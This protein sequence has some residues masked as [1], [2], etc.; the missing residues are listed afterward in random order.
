MP[1]PGEKSNPLGL[2][3]FLDDLQLD[4]YE[5]LLDE[6]EELYRE[7][8]EARR[9]P[10]DE[11]DEVGES[12]PLLTLTV[13]GGEGLAF[14]ELPLLSFGLVRVAAVG[15]NGFRL[16]PISHPLPGYA[17]LKDPRKYLEDLLARSG[18]SE[19]SYALNTFFQA[20]GISLED[21][22]EHYAKDLKA[23]VGIFRDLL[24]WAY[25][26]WTVE[27]VLGDDYR[28][29]LFVKDGRLAQTGVKDEFRTKLREYFRRKD[30]LLVGV[31][32]RSRLLAEGLTSL[33]MARLFAEVR[34]TFLLRVPEAIMEKAYRYERQWDA[35]FQGA[36]VMGTRYVARLFESTFRPRE[37]IV[38]LDLPPHLE[39]EDAIRVAKS[40]KSHRSVLYKGSLGPVVEAHGK[41]SVAKPL[42]T[43]MEDEV[44]SRLRKSFGEEFARKIAEWLRLAERE[45]GRG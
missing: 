18:E 14:E 30:L 42:A 10:L 7:V 2:K 15:V 43:S 25:L 8:K 28:K 41:A 32:K 17:V 21:L 38:I 40:L 34:G 22:G 33:V 6:L 24:E 5:E 23:F 37:G 45:V 4:H 44:L 26:V 11:A 36:F 20:T 31:S 12:Y 35:D 3:G 13:D 29:Y 9:T 27:K 16:P 1:F 19:A 39:E